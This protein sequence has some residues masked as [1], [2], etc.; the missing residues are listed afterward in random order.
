MPARSRAGVVR[1]A[2]A[3]GSSTKGW[4]AAVADA[5]KNAADEAPE[6][7]GVEVARMWADLDGRR[8]LRTFHA[9]VK[10][11]YRQ[12]LRIARSARS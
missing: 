1:I 5:V 6:P 4:E 12:G 2:E 8:R 9:A 11:A 3:T 7:I 10:V